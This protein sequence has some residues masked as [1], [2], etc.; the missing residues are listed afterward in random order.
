MVNLNLSGKRALVTGSTAGIGESIS[1]LAGEGVSV[2]V[3]GRDGSRGSS[4]A[5][6]LRRNGVG[7]SP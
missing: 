5:G 6:A 7:V 4:L 1:L 3:H 2:L